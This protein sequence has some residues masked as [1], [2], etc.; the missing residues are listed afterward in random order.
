[1]QAGTESIST[2]SNAFEGASSDL[3]AA[4]GPIRS[5]QDRI[6]ASLRQLTNSTEAAATTVTT[7]SEAVAKNAATTLETA[8]VALGQE[9]EGIVANLEATRGAMRQISEQ[10]ETLDDIDEKLGIALQHYATTFDQSLS[11]A[12]SHIRSMQQILE[13]GIDTL[14]SVVEQAEAFVPQARRV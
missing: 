13:P 9:R 10:A 1:M 6:E 5:S 12:E 3:V 2:A 8:R 4:A 11:T 14:R 7:A